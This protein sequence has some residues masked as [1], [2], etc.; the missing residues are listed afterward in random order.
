MRLDETRLLGPD[1]F[2]RLIK[3]TKDF[4]GRAKVTRLL[5]VYQ[6]WTH[7]LYP[8]TQFRDT[9]QRV[10][11]LCHTKRMHVALSV[12]R[13]EAHGKTHTYEDDEDDGAIVDLTDKNPTEVHEL[14]DRASAPGSDTVAYASSSPP[15]SRPP[16][17]AS[18]F[19]DDDFDIDAIIQ[20]EQDLLAKKMPSNP[21]APVDKQ[22]QS[23][24]RDEDEEMWNL[25]ND[26]PPVSDA[27]KA[28]PSRDIVVTEQSAQNVTMDDDQNMWEAI[29][30]LEES[31]VAASSAHPSAH[32]TSIT[33]YDPDI[34]DMYL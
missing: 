8:K 28:A 19:D 22:P 1:G 2:P 25:F 33:D 18:E 15:A 31:Q 11:K 14:E 27:H 3:Q 23:L 30:E 26:P 13:D 29:D 17:S 20:A 21:S 9:V 7:S 5:Q 6:F 32:D 34:E 4:R 16:T 12:W 10:E 24:S